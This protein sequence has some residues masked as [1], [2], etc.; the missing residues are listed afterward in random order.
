MARAMPQR[1]AIAA[2]K[3]MA[4]WGS[5]GF[6]G[7]ISKRHDFLDVEIFHFRSVEHLICLA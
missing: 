5:T 4:V 1:P 6:N 2:G 3:A 7:F